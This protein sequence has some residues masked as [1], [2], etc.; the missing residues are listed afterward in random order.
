MLGYSIANG[1]NKFP[2]FVT[3]LSL[4]Q[5]AGK[6]LPATRR[7]RGTVILTC[8]QECHRLNGTP[9]KRLGKN[10]K[11]RVATYPY[12]RMERVLND[13]IHFIY[14]HI[15]YHIQFHEHKIGPL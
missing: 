2:L 15:I 8:A 6:K 14:I 3:D 11:M 7:R 12:H 1:L 13:D 9:V 5:P 10:G 4:S